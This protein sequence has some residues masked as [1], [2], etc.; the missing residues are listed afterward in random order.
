VKIGSIVPADMKIIEGD[1]IQIDQSALTGESLPVTKKINDVIFS[2]SIA[3]QGEVVGVV[4]N[5]GLN[6]F[7]GRT[8]KL[9]A[10]AEKE[11]RS[12]FQKAVMHIGNYLILLTIFLVA[13]ILFAAIFRHEQMIEVIRFCLV[14]TV[15]AIPVAL[16]A[17]L[18]LTMA[19]GAINLA[20]RKA[21]ISRLAAIDELAGVSVLCSDKTGT[22]TQNK[23]TVSDPILFDKNSSDDLMMYSALASKEENNDPIEV[24]VFDYL[25][26]NNLYD[27]LKDYKQTRFKPFD[28][29]SKRTEAEITTKSGDKIIVTKGA[30]QVILGLC[31]KNIDRDKVIKPVNDLAGKGYRTLGVALKKQDE[32]S[33]HYVGLIPLFDP[34]REDSKDTI[35]ETEKLH[36]DVKMLTGDNIAIAK[37]IAEI[38]G[39]G[40]NILD[41]RQLRGADYREYLTLSRILSGAIYSKLNPKVNETDAKGFAD[42]I[43]KE[44]EK[45]FEDNPLPDG[46]IKKHESEI[47]ELIKSADG[48][49][50]VFPEDKYFIVDKLQKAGTIVAM[51][52]DGVNDAPALRKAD[53]GI[54]V[55][56]ATDAA[57]AAASLV[58]LAPGLSVIVNAIKMARVTF[59]RMKSYAY[60]RIAETLRVIFFMTLS[61]L[62]FKFYPVTALM[63]IL[64]ALL[65]D[66]PILAIAY[67]RTKIDEYPIRWNMREIM[68]VATILGILGVIASFGIFVIAKLLFKLPSGAIQT[69]VF[70]KLAVA[71][72]LTIF[73][74]RTEGRFWRKPYPAP[75]LLWSAIGTK[76]AATLFAVY[77][78]L[79]SPIGWT[80]ALIIWGYALAWMVVNDFVKV[81]VFKWLRRERFSE[82]EE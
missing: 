13:L 59:E 54:A 82:G 32:S 79:V 19:V 28:P 46:Y 6:T 69:F 58:L 63:I 29:V 10:K 78:L 76:F 43:T 72:H 26:K 74:T 21:V 2:N 65:N 52:G 70:L 50:Q 5:T 66:L 15:A 64:L 12:H 42:D 81:A 55:S 44:V 34:P 35:A 25:K 56:G 68:I 75:I 24:P 60:Y 49:A 4:L 39:L 9:V 30:P 80:N 22:L 62:I 23:M 37:H 51:T 33:F 3:K 53:I 36:L 77:G 47:V 73:L 71:G 61:I 18:T 1:Y 45:Y 31:K 14:L 17:V 20:K 57:R 11:E 40:K 8:V 27:K 16:P 7:F 67:D 48:F 38:L 41:S